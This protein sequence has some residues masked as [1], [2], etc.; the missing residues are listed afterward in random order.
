MTVIFKGAAKPLA[1]TDLPRLGA[2]IGVGE[3]EIHAII[4]VESAGSGFDGY[5]RVKALFEPHK[6]YAALSGSERDAAVSQGLAYPKW[7]EKPYPADSYARILAAIAI[8]EA[9]ALCSTSWGM[10]QIM[11]FN[12]SLCGFVSVQDMV[13]AFAE[14]EAAQLEAMI[15]FLSSTGA[16]K[17]LADHNWVLMAKIYNGAGFARNNYALK[18]A[19]AFTKWRAIKDTPYPKP[20]QPEAGSISISKGDIMFAGAKTY[21]GASSLITLLLSMIGSGAIPIL[22][23]IGAILATLTLAALRHG[24]STTA[25]QIVD[26]IISAFEGNQNVLIASISKMTDDSIKKALADYAAAQVIAA[27]APAAAKAIVQ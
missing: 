15:K 14:S 26:Q 12:H 10:G 19:A 2:L 24:I 6:F 17:A 16:D 20:R 22:P 9:A 27:P 21:M 25:V 18:L 3:D 8:N 13:S 4:D 1:D 7:G 23:A 11:G 5:G